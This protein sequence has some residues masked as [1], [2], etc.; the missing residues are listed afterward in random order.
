MEPSERFLARAARFVRFQESVGLRADDPKNARV[1]AELNSIERRDP[2]MRARIRR[3]RE[4]ARD[5][6]IAYRFNG[7]WLYVDRYLRDFLAEYN[8]R[9]FMGEGLQQPLSFNVMGTFVEPDPDALVL[10]LLPEKFLSVNI[11][12]ILDH[13]T[14]PNQKDEY[15]CLNEWLNELTIYEMNVYGGYADLV[16]AGQDRLVFCG[17]ACVRELDELSIMAVFGRRVESLEARE[18]EKLGELWPGKEFLARDK[19]NIDLSDI[20]LFDD[21][22]V[23]PVILMTR[24]A[25]TEKKFQ[26]R[27]VFEEKKDVFLT[28]TD[29]PQALEEL[30]SIPEWR[31][32]AKATLERVQA[33]SDAFDL[34][35]RV[36]TFL[37]RLNALDDDIVIERHPT[38]L[39]IEP[40]SKIVRTLRKNL[41][42]VDAPNYVEVATLARDPL[43]EGPFEV[44]PSGLV[45]E[46]TGHWKT[47]SLDA[48]GA[49]KHGVPTQGKTWVSATK[50]WYEEFGLDPERKEPLPVAVSGTGTVGSLYVMRS[51]MHPKDVYKVGYTSKTSDERATGLESTSGQ[52]DQFQVIQE[53]LVKEP[54]VIEAEVHRRLAAYRLNKSRE[55][56]RLKYRQI[57][58]CIEDVIDQAD[59]LVESP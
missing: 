34:L 23:T 30:E 17:A 31:A 14:S 40:N 5:L 27:Y 58:E 21:P 44:R 12:Q 22:N 53:W 16:L 59:A 15:K 54:R 9:L 18:P 50:S 2:K 25:L 47:L 10:R 42:L 24:L 35:E 55:F 26:V 39:K 1:V 13:L 32:T 6:A 43:A 20:G 29:D 33:Y 52:P 4:R 19:E 49:D 56:F 48:V 36:P 3:A 37:L 38:R 41:S 28:S 45:V 7:P 51:G 11:S 8:N 57:R 46:T